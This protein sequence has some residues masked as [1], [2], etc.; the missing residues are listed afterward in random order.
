MLA[1]LVLAF[2]ALCAVAAVARADDSIAPTPSSATQSSTQMLPSLAL[3]PQGGPQAAPQ[4][5]NP[6]QRS[7][8]SGLYVGTDVFAT[9]GK[10]VRGGVGGDGYAGY[11]HEFSNNVVVGVQAGAGYAP[12]LS[13]F[14]P[15]GF[16]Y[17][18]TN[19][20]IGYDMGRLMPFVTLGVDLAKPA[21]LSNRGF[22]SASDSVNDLFDSSGK[23]NSL[24]TIGA[25]F[26]Y[27]I[28]NNVTMGVEVNV[29]QNHGFWGPLAPLP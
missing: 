11:N 10:G 23:L 14:G 27:A 24:T 6:Q 21:G 17:T 1:R 2:L 12:S 26:N 13:K 3:D 28:T 15:R 4:S 25:G 22:T 8:W 20:Q 5:G 16:D 18:S 19:V 9:A 7:L 29:V